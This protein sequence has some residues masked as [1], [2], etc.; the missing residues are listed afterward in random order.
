MRDRIGRRDRIAEI[1][2]RGDRARRA[3]HLLERLAVP[4]DRADPGPRARANRDQRRAEPRRGAGDEDAPARERRRAG[5][6]SP[7]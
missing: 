3:C 6:V 2:G 5:S 4:R 1:G 7:A